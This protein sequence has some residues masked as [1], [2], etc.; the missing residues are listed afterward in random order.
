MPSTVMKE[1]KKFI[2]SGDDDIG[3]RIIPTYIPR[4]HEPNVYMSKEDEIDQSVSPT[5]IPVPQE[6]NID[7]IYILGN[8][9]MG[10]YIHTKKEEN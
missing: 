1:I 6:P 8:Y 9:E 3:Q 2:M 10:S 5:I 4:P 7:I